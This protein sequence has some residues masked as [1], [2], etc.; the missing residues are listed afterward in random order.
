M[1]TETLAII[2]AR[3]G[4]K[5]IPRKNVLDFA[6]HPLIAYSIAAAL[7]S[8]LVT[9]VIVSTDDEEIAEVARKYGAETPFMRPAEHAQDNTPD[10]PV[11]KH[12]LDWLAENED[13]KPEIVVQLRPTN[14]VRP[15][16]MVD[17]AVQLLI[18]HPE[19][20]SVRG[21][22]PAGQNPHKMWQLNEDGSM[23]SLLDVEGIAEP[24]NAPRQILP[25]I[26]WQT[27]HIDAIRVKTIYE[28][29]S[30]TGDVVWPLY[31]DVAY[32]LDIDTSYD[33]AEAERLMKS[34]RV[35][36]VA[37]GSVLPNKIDLIVLD[38][39]GV[40]TDNR[41]WVDENGLERVA[42][43]RGDGMGIALLKKA[44]YQV[45]ILST[46]TNPVVA[47]RAK[48]LDV[49]VYQGIADKGS[50]LQSLLEEKNLDPANVIYVGNDV[51]DLPCFPLV[52][53]PVAVADAHPDVL[54]HAKLVLK[55]K[56]GFG[57]VRELSDMILKQKVQE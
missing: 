43:H 44:G 35:A 10:F 9:R 26:Y 21:I 23:R 41:V 37:P 6:G 7:Q 51:N 45:M 12:A 18:D 16:G 3:G 40:L 14:P 24:Y 30:L 34:G 4:S 31:I 22:V 38:F 8:E 47:A 13:Y 54:P 39:D 28:K 56:G 32:T 1:T 33:W 48:K 17:A 57:A 20:D 29:D 49:P 2:P 5:S 55:T 52:G 15:P 11:F 46:E 27:G 36:A 53:C 50:A 25:D 42:A 19:A